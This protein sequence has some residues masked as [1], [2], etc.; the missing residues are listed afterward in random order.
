MIAEEEGLK[1]RLLKSIESCQ[2][3]LR[4]LY[5]ELQL[6]PFEVQSL[7]ICRFVCFLTATSPLSLF[8]MCRAEEEEEG[9]T[10]LQM[11][12]NSR[13][14][15]EVMKEHKRQRMEELK[16]LVA[17]DQELCGI[18]CTTPFAIDHNSV[19]SLQ[20][21]KNYHAYLDDLTKEKVNFSQLFNSYSTRLLRCNQ[22]WLVTGAAS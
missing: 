1:N 10:M 13:T 12:K 16:G 20:T 22:M 2:E 18:M 9:C 11:E 19:P 21:L 4:V 7:W 14:R 15:L 5:S 17:K 6:P 8:V 3:E